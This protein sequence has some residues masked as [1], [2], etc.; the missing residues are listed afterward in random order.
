MCPA[1]FLQTLPRWN[2]LMPLPTNFSRP[3]RCICPS[4]FTKAYSFLSFLGSVVVWSNCVAIPSGWELCDHTAS[5][6]PDLR[7]RFVLGKSD[8]VYNEGAT[9][10]SSSHYHSLSGGGVSINAHTLSI[11]QIPPHNH[12]NG[13]YNQLL[14]SNCDGTYWWGSDSSCGEP[15]LFGSGTTPS[16]GGGGSH[17]HGA[18]L[19]GTTPSTSNMPPYYVMCYILKL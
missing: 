2:P 14:K 11:S 13:A 8:G 10:G 16:Q 7:G 9:G 18:S 1:R 17:S 6:C 4:F 3:V 12:A 15:D 5:T 19:G